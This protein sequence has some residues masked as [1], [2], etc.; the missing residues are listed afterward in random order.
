M[1]G[2]IDGHVEID[3]LFSPDAD[4]PLKLPTKRQHSTYSS[5]AKRN[6]FR[7]LVILLLLADFTTFG[8]VVRLLLEIQLF[9][10]LQMCSPCN[11]L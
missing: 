4:H 5:R 1:N 9:D 6:F 8:P 3:L 7:P 10:V 2:R 11:S